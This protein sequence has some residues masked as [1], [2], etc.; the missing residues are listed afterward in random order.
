MENIH[1]PFVN[2]PLVSVV[3]CTYNGERFLK[4]QM[5]SILSQTYQNIEIIISD[6]ASTDNTKDVLGEY[7]KLANVRVFFQPGN[8]GYTKNFEFALSKATG[9]YIALSDQD[10]VWLPTK[11]EELLYHFPENAMLIYSNSQH[12]DEHGN[13]LKT[14]NADIKRF[15]TGSDARSFAY[16][17]IIYGHSAM[18]KKELLQYALPIPE[19]AT[20]DSWLAYIA[21]TISRIVYHDKVLTYYRRH[22]KTATKIEPPKR[23]KRRRT[24]DKRYQKYQQELKWFKALKGGANNNYKDFF[25]KLYNLYLQKANGHYNFKLLFFLLRYNH[26]LYR[27]SKK[28]FIS[29]LIAI[30]KSARGERQF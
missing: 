15:Y 14:T 11:I 18:V 8:V 28:G 25:E 16:I 23:T 5:D 6:D 27:F 21:T 26:A 13:F 9:E 10:D 22:E 24:A 4:E 12:T 20:H 1:N 17:N 29:R 2:K 30:R 7:S 19:G 3:M